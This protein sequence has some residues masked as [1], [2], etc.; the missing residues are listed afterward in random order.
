MDGIRHWE[1]SISLFEQEI[2]KA[3]QSCGM[4]S[5]GV[6]EFS[7]FAQGTF[8]VANALSKATLRV[9]IL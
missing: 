7:N 1:A 8:E 4:N 9:L 2:W 6:F 5:I 3:K